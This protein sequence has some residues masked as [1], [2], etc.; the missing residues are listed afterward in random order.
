MPSQLVELTVKEVS[1]VDRAANNRVFHIAK[2]DGTS[3]EKEQPADGDVHAYFSPYESPYEAY[4]AYMNALTDLRLRVNKRLP[5][6][7]QI[8][9][10]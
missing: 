10:G 4:I 9:Q 3:V 7:Q 6:P 1:G 5:T 8:G 2:A